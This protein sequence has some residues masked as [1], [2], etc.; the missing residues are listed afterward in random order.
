MRLVRLQKWNQGHTITKRAINDAKN[1]VASTKK[2]RK[3]QATP[4]VIIRFDLVT[5]STILVKIH[6]MISSNKVETAVKRSPR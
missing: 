6:F 2:I 1:M 3:S 5:P 4:R